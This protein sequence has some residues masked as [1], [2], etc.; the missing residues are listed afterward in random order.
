MIFFLCF[1][2]W[3][4]GLFKTQLPLGWEAVAGTG[5]RAW[6]LSLSLERPLMVKWAGACVPPASWERG[7]HLLLTGR[8]ETEVRSGGPASKPSSCLKWRSP[9]D[10]FQHERQRNWTGR[11]TWQRSI[12]AVTSAAGS[13]LQGHTGPRCPRTEPPVLLHT[14]SPSAPADITP[15][16]GPLTRPSQQ[17]G[18]SKACRPHEGTCVLHSTGFSALWDVTMTIK[19][20]AFKEG[21]PF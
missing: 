5:L 10:P 2:K 13:V 7:T 8:K 19:T 20:L 21:F 18:Q 15:T 1:R 9:K 6:L 11:P 16:H 12:G 3:L 14:V 17:A 4:L